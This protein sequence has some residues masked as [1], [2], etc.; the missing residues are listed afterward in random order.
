MTDMPPPPPPPPPVVPGGGY[1]D[2]SQA[3][4]A[5]VLSILG[6]CCWPTAIAGIVIANSEKQGIANGRRDPGTGGTAQAAFVIGI[7]MLAIGLLSTG[8]WF[9]LW[10]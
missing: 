5:L 9:R 7:V 6:L 4:L 10:R 3:T 1:P 8:F 2:K